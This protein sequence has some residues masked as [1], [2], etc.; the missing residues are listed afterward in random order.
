M[1]R[2]AKFKFGETIKSGWTPHKL[3]EQ[4]QKRVRRFGWYVEDTGWCSADA[5][6]VFFNVLSDVS[7]VR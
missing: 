3:I 5:Y 1:Y 2:K 4:I 6:F 7:S